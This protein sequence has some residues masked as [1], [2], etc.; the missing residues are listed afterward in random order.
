MFDARKSQGFDGKV[1]QRK[2]DAMHA[3][4]LYDLVPARYVAYAMI[5]TI[6]VVGPICA[7]LGYGYAIRHPAKVG[8]IGNATKLA[9]ACAIVI[10]AAKS[11]PDR[12][13][14]LDPLLF[15]N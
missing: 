5:L 13:V 10:E 9:G 4:M 1:E 11:D 7:V 8:Y 3:R 12:Q 6:L 15:D 14:G 2:I